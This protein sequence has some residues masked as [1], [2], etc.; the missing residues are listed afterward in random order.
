MA[1]NE[2]LVLN[3]LLHLPKSEFEVKYRYRILHDPFFE[4][5]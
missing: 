3:F 2:D 5:H 4:W 1:F